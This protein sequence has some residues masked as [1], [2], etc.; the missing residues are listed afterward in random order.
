MQILIWNFKARSTTSSSRFSVSHLLLS[1]FSIPHPETWLGR[2][3]LKEVDFSTELFVKATCQNKPFSPLLIF[4]LVHLRCLSH[5]MSCF[6]LL[7]PLFSGF[8]NNQMCYYSNE[9]INYHPPFPLFH[10]LTCLQSQSDS[11][12]NDLPQGLMW[13]HIARL[14]LLLAHP[15]YWS[16]NRE[17]RNTTT[18]Q[19]LQI[20][21][22][23]SCWQSDTPISSMSCFP[24][25]H[26]IG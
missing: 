23:T 26:F 18:S 1:I 17:Q 3:I 9:V 15:D 4:P 10:R 21:S 11:H 5:S 14:H 22:P 16:F 19:L 13:P 2:L 25:I 7:G 12:L 24:N 20:T 8:V 6:P